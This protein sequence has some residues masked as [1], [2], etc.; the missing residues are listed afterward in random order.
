MGK[1]TFDKDVFAINNAGYLDES[2]VLNGLQWNAKD[3]TV[4]QNSREENSYC[5]CNCN[6]AIKDCFNNVRTK[7][8]VLYTNITNTFFN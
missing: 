8:S 1:I 6:L 2:S 3:C 4:L 7:L 5:N